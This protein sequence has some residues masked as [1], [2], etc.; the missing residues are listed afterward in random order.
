MAE[1]EGPG[2]L[3]IPKGHFVRPVPQFWIGSPGGGDPSIDNRAA[4]T[5]GSQPVSEDETTLGG[6]VYL[7]GASMSLDVDEPLW[8]EISVYDASAMSISRLLVVAVDA[9][10]AGLQAHL[11]GVFPQQG[12][13]GELL[14]GSG[15]YPYGS[16]TSTIPSWIG[17]P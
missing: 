9:S 5:H 15:S 16:V 6:G 3:N 10:P 13:I 12:T 7:A 8:S 4:W 1:I 2:V 14:E 11:V 17:K